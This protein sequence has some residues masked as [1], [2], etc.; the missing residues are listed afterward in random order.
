MLH[1]FAVRARC[2]P[3]RLKSPNR[4]IDV[5]KSTHLKI[6]LRVGSNGHFQMRRREPVHL[7]ICLGSQRCIKVQQQ[8]F[9]GRT[10]DVGTFEVDARHERTR[11]KSGVLR[12]ISACQPL[13][14]RRAKFCVRGYRWTAAAD[15]D[16]Q[17]QDR[18]ANPHQALPSPAP[19]VRRC[20][21]GRC[22][23]RRRSC[24]RER[25]PSPPPSSPSLMRPGIAPS[26][27]RCRR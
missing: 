8:D 3:S 24:D 20:A 23:S 27:R 9:S 10:R 26:H 13:P 19:A 11:S 17:K 1:A 2:C 21:V 14:V 15:A 22:A 12:G 6:D 4:D 16:A 7:Y 18:H 5:L 25:S